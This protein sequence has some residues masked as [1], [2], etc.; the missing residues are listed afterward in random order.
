MS[1]RKSYWHW[2]VEEGTIEVGSFFYELF[3]IE[4]EQSV[5]PFELIREKFADEDAQNFRLSIDRHLNS[6]GKDPFH[7][8]T[9]HTIKETGEIISIIWFGE[10]L[11]WSEEKKPLRMSG[12]IKRKVDLSTRDKLSKMEAFFFSRLMD[13]LNE[14]I[15]YKDLDSKFIRINKECAKKF[16]MSH[17]DE[18]IGKSD[19]DIF[20]EEHAR[21][22]YNDEQRILATE[23]GII[24]QVEKE[25]FANE[26]NKIAWASTTKLPLYDDDG[27]LIGTFGITRD[28]TRQKELEKDLEYNDQLFSK[29][30][31]LAPGFLYLHHVDVDKNIAFPFASEGIREL[32]DLAPDD[33]KNSINPLMRRVHKDDLK[34]VLGSIMDSVKYVSEWNCE[35]RIIHPTKGLRWVRGRAKP[36][37]QADGS[38]LSPGYLTDITQ[39]KKVYEANE[40]L[41]RQFQSVFNTD[42]NLIFVKDEQ[43][44]YIMVNEAACNFFN[45]QRV[46]L[47]GKTDF[48]LGIPEQEAQR[49]LEADRKVIETQEA[50][51]FS[52]FKTTR[53]NGDELWHQTIKVPFH[54]GTSN[55]ESVLSIV[56][57]IT[58]RKQKEL[59]LSETLDIIGE[60]NQRLTNFAHIVSHNLRN[61]AGNISMLLSLYDPDESEKEK[62]ETIEYLKKASDNLNESI[63]DL[64]EI[65]DKQQTTISQKKIVNLKKYVDKTK[66]ILTSEILTN[67]VKIIES[68]PEN[69]SFEYNPAYLESVIL[70]MISNAIKYR[71]PNVEPIVEI[72]AYEEEGHIF[73]EISDNGLGIDLKRHGKKLFGMYKTFHGNEN[74]KGIGL[75]IT[76]NQIDAMGGRINVESEPGKGT[77]FK[78]RFK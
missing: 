16:G 60:Q 66:E 17:P 25:T 58:E 56:T 35:Y 37:L 71:N 52:D 32:F 77:T 38:V 14:S 54:R 65:V 10:V 23:E 1:S 53:D 45:M 43:G 42:P 15:F 48:E 49:Y 76:K 24:H 62:A 36:E 50:T 4:P 64:N 40:E 73:F 8:E 67:N 78:I 11:R 59:E 74:A 13:Q 12:L 61:H 7:C 39:E 6:G 47:I 3:S 29:L 46:D 22:A 27:E 31:E 18:A 34:R 68:I 20:G 70:N 26:P 75:F 72:K 30:S 33:I 21:R 9:K 55:E 44:K 19:F 69:L 28:I 57:D 2:N 41:K 5:I 63:A 51:F